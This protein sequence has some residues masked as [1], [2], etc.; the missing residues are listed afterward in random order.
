MDTKKI[1]PRCN[2][3]KII[4]GQCEC[5]MEW[6]SSDGDGGLEDCQC[7]PE[8]ECPLCKGVGVVD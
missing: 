3:K 2:G 1:C 8:Q 4:E 5:N 7:E 6:R